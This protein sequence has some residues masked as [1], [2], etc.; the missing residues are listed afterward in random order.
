MKTIQ[1]LTGRDYGSAQVLTIT[2]TPTTD[3]IADVAAEFIDSVRG[4]SGRVV[5]LGFNASPLLI[6]PAVLREY[7][8][9]RYTEI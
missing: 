2:Y 4:I 8:A 5:V 1:Y 7:D 3:D 6:G 9:G